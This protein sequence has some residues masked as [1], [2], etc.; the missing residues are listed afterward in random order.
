MT[1]GDHMRLLSGLRTMIGRIIDTERILEIQRCF[2]QNWSF[3]KAEAFLL[4]GA[5]CREY[6]WCILAG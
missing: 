2:G 1:L 4:D 6:D 3:L 5:G